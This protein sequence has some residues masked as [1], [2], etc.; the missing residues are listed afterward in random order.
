MILPY[1]AADSVLLYSGKAEVGSSPG[2]PVTPGEVEA[3]KVG[4]LLYTLV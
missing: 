2:A 1:A 4:G 3:K